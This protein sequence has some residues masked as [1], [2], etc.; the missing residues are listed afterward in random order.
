MEEVAH[1]AAHI[2][3]GFRRVRSRRRYE[4]AAKGVGREK[5][6]LLE[7]PFGA[8]IFV[9]IGKLVGIEV[10]QPAHTRV[11]VV[12]GLPGNSVFAG[13]DVGEDFFV[14]FRTPGLRNRLWN[15]FI[16]GQ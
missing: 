13:F 3:N 2:E 10:V 12:N 6:S 11:T 5:L 9:V 7:L 1:S 8:G 4:L 16:H 15:Y 14:D